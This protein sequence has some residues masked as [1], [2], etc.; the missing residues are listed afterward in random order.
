MRQNLIVRATLIAI[1]VS[2]LPACG[3]HEYRPDFAEKACAEQGSVYWIR[4]VSDKAVARRDAVLTDG[5]SAEV[6][7]RTN[8]IIE[9]T[10][11]KVVFTSANVSFHGFSAS[12]FSVSYKDVT[13]L[14]LED[15]DGNKDT[16]VI[17]FVESSDAGKE[18]IEQGVSGLS[19]A[20]I[21]GLQNFLAAQ[22]VTL[23]T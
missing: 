23:S 10:E 12:P 16:L 11:L 22:G 9:P 14:R 1:F 17:D 7:K 15:R 8:A 2:V 4:L 21:D 20:C 18:T 19:S 13:Y 5:Q 6:V 3:S